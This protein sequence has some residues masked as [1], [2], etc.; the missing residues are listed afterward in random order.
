MRRDIVEMTNAAGSGH[1]G[2]SL[3]AVEMLVALYFEFLKHDPSNP[4]WEDRDR[5]IICKCHITPA[6]YS[7]LARTG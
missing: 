1:P 4:D 6:I 5:M 3:S 2:G 7:I